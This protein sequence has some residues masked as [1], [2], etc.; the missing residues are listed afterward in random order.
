MLGR[1]EEAR[2]DGDSTCGTLQLSGVHNRNL[3]LHPMTTSEKHAC[4]PRI[5]WKWFGVALISHECYSE[6]LQIK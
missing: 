2:Q 1:V 5:E 3:P 4:P 6:L